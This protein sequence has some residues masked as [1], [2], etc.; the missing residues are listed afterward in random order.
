MRAAKYNQYPVDLR[1]GWENQQRTLPV[2]ETTHQTHAQRCYCQVL[3][4]TARHSVTVRYCFD[5]YSVT[6]I[7]MNIMMMMMMMMMSVMIIE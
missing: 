6:H 7:M 1:Q 3:C 5:D 2:L 4:I